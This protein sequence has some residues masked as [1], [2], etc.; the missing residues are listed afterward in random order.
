MADITVRRTHGMELD[1]AKGKVRDIVSDLEKDADYI[2]KVKWNSDGTAAD[3]KG[4]GFKGN[5][6]VDDQEVVVDIDLKLLA[7]PFK[8][9]IKEKVASRMDNYFG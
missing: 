5:F 6:R 2:D 1:E 3:V 9:K 4:K 7:K 8:G